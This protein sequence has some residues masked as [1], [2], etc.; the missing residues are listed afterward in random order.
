AGIRRVLYGYNAVFTGLLLL[1]LLVLAN[2]MVAVVFTANVE[3]NPKMGMQ[4][5]APRS[6][7]TLEGLKD[8]V[9][10]YVLMAR[11]SESY[12]EVRDLLDNCQSITDKLTVQEIS[13]DLKEMEYRK[14]VDKYP[15]V[16]E[17]TSMA[18]G[19]RGESGRGLLITYGEA[20]AGQKLP[21]EFIP[22]SDLEGPDQGRTHRLFFGERVLME[23]IRL[24]SEKG[25]TKPKIYVTQDNGELWIDDGDYLT[26]GTS[27]RV[28]SLLRYA[29]GGEFANMLRKDNFEVQGLIWE[30]KPNIPTP[31]M[32]SFS[33][34]S[35]KDKHE[36]PDDCSVLLI[37]NPEKAFPKDVL[38]AIDRYMDKRNGKLMILT[39]TGIL[40][41]SKIADD[42]LVDLCKKYN[43]Q[44]NKDFVMK[45]S[46]RDDVMKV[47]V[48]VVPTAQNKVA[49]EFANQRYYFVMPR[50]MSPMKG[51]SSGYN[52]EPF[53]HVTKEANGAPVGAE[54]DTAAILKQ[55]PADY[56]ATIIER[57]Q[58][59]NKV[60]PEP[61]IVGM[62]ITDRDN[63]ARVVVIGGYT[64]VST[65]ILRK[66]TDA[67]DNFALF[68]SCL[69]WL[70]DRDIVDIGIDPKESGTYHPRE[71]SKTRLVALPIALLAL[72]LAGLG[73]GIWIVRRK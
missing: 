49:Q 47:K 21:H 15:E 1:A 48:T 35:P 6:K 27:D 44:L 52:A 56:V 36:V 28:L 30:A 43:V 26:K 14:L 37:A 40:P 61:L 71:T 22:E 33:K 38:E 10:V 20:A 25:K 68:R 11:G 57:G 34:A 42:G 5:L 66:S 23:K 29:G 8:R 67:R 55:H 70:A 45:F 72:A 51:P 31:D 54:T 7:V 50:T 65:P 9:T 59:G 39:N 53:L 62:T 46:P 16:G 12:L 19:G 64:F 63:K 69:S 4:S 17:R 24:L 2:I 58:L 32:F 41:E 73:T 18:P 60:S 3:W 13:P